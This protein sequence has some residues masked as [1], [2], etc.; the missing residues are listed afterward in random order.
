MSFF[1]TLELPSSGNITV[2]ALQRNPLPALRELVDR[3]LVISDL[4]ST[5][6]WSIEPHVPARE[7]AAVLAA[8]N[9]DVAGV[10]E[11]PLV[12]CVTLEDLRRCDGVVTDA[13][14]PI[15]AADSVER[16]LALADFVNLLRNRPHVFVLDHDRVG[17]IATRAD[18]QAPA[19]SVVVLA[20][21]VATEVGA[22]EIVKATLGETW[23]DRVPKDR[24]DKARALFEEKQ[25]R[26]VATGLEDCLYF[27]DWINLIARTEDLR[28]P[29]GFSSRR[30]FETATGPFTPLRNDLAHGGTLLDGRSPDEAIDLFGR[31]RDFAERIWAAAEDSGPPWDA[32]AAST[33]TAGDGTVLAGPDASPTLPWDPPV[34]VITAWNPGSDT[35]P[36]Q[37]NQA[38]NARLESVLTMHQLSFST[39]EGRSP[40]G[41]WTEEGFLVAGLG[42][43]RATELGEQ[44]GQAA[45]FELTADELLVVRCPDETVTRRAPRTRK[46]PT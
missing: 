22:V 15:L 7:A 24:Q 36:E 42:R 3:T 19:V 18:L 29:L 32:Y 20:Y 16:S 43:A 25:S 35:L 10:A 14:R 8:R 17:W 27:S 6:I 39:V 30:A 23:F 44:F 37:L 31:I 12:R 45:V 9:F 46:L 26:G 21:L 34:Y 13:A 11:D 2:V 4:I 1:L 33:L 40:D 41:T 5:R 28:T 38:A